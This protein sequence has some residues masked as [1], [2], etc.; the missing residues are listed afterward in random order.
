M[1]TSQHSNFLGLTLECWKVGKLGP[2]ELEGWKVGML[3]CWKVGMFEC[4]EVRPKTVGKL[5][6]QAEQSWKVGK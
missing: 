6:S 2:K 4:W 1:P 3:E 5:E